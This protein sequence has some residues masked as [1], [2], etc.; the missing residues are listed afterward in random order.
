[1]SEPRGKEK[2]NE[3]LRTETSKK[4]WLWLTPYHRLYR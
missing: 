1:M 2:S 3:D 4:K